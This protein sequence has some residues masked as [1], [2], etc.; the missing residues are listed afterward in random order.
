MIKILG[1]KFI[2]GRLEFEVVTQATSVESFDLLLS[3]DTDDVDVNL[4]SVSG[5]V[6]WNAFPNWVAPGQLLI[7]GFTSSETPVL[8]GGTLVKVSIGLRPGADTSVR[9]TLEGNYNDPVVAIQ[10]E[11]ITLAQN[12]A[13]PVLDLQASFW[14][15]LAALPGA[16]IEAEGGTSATTGSDGHAVLP[17]PTGQSAALQVSRTVPVAEVAR[18][19]GSVN[20]QDAVFILKMIA[21]QSAN[22]GGAPVSRFKSLAADFDGSGTVSLAD[23]LGVLRHAVGLP[24]PTPSW[25]FVEEG[26]DALSSVLSPGVPGPVTVDVTPPGPIEVNLIGVLRGDV[27]GSYGVYGS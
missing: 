7:G 8:A 15:G 14:K 5:P 9:V 25:V 22:D 2:A 4:L 27:D 18:S 16:L 20:L 1:A 19:E 10:P 6:G 11:T 12:A 3:F 17:A 24:A 21:G 23:A 26:D 13:S